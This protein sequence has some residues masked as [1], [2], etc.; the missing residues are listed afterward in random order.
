MRSVLYSYPSCFLVAR[1]GLNAI[2]KAATPVVHEAT[3]F[4][5]EI[6]TYHGR[7]CSVVQTSED[8]EEAVAWVYLAENGGMSGWSI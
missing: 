3:S 2:T 4:L 1:A 6:T 8:E 7:A 5:D